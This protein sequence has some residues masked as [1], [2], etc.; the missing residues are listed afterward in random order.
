V[1]LQG[2]ARDGARLVA[3]GSPTPNAEQAVL[4]TAGPA[5][6][7]SVAVT[8]CAGTGRGEARVV[9]LARHQW[10]L[11]FVDLGTSTLTATARMPC[12]V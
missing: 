11:P 5:E 7:T 12:E 8:P 1:A 3:L 6:V 10:R 2:A 9:V 4:A